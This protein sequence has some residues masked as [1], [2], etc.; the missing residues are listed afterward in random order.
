MTPLQL[1]A[2]LVVLMCSDGIAPSAEHETLRQYAN[3]ESQL[4][5]FK[6][7]IDAYHNM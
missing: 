3:R 4:H 1:K 6:D 7:W 2:L 5:G